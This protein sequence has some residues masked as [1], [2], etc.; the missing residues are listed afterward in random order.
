MWSCLP[1]GT[2]SAQ[3]EGER[4]AHEQTKREACEARAL[5][6]K[7]I[8]V[9]DTELQDLRHQIEALRIEA[10]TLTERAAHADE[11][12]GL[13]K[14]LQAGQGDRRVRGQEKANEEAPDPAA[15]VGDMNRP[16]GERR[17]Y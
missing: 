13:V 17:L 9:Q 7:R 6:E 1:R 16:R 3:L 12:R 5:A 10:A 11:L 14:S 2:G 8:A 4:R 15:G